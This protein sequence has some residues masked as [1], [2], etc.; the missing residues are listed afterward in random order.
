MSDS[1]KGAP[2]GASG[3]ISFIHEVDGAAYDITITKRCYDLRFGGTM[4]DDAHQTGEARRQM[5]EHIAEE[6]IRNGATSPVV[7]DLGD[8]PDDFVP[9]T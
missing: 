4:G 3:D 1:T 8:I 6:K 5:I 2:S 9:R 7:I